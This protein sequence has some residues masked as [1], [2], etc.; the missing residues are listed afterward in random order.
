MLLPSVVPPLFLFAINYRGKAGQV[1]CKIRSRRDI[2]DIKKDLPTDKS[3]LVAG[4]GFEPTTS[5]L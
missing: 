5:G 4:A 1:E 3:Y 2:E